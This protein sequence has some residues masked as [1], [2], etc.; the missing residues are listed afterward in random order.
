[1][2]KYYLENFVCMYYFTIINQLSTFLYM[3]QF[4]LLQNTTSLTTRF[5]IDYCDPK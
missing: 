5:V 3:Y 2:C 1:M 4:L